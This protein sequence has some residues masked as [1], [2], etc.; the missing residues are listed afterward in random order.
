M[1]VRYAPYIHNVIQQHNIFVTRWHKVYKLGI[2]WY[3]I[4]HIIQQ[5]LCNIQEMYI[6][7]LPPANVR[8]LAFHLQHDMPFLFSILEQNRT[9]NTG[10]TAALLYYEAHFPQT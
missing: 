6:M 4:C 7:A 2:I 9:H 10:A 8:S 5:V 3:S 1:Y